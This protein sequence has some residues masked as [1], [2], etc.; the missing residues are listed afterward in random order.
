MRKCVFPSLL[1]ATQQAIQCALENCAGS[2]N[3]RFLIGIDATCGNGYDTLFLYKNFR[4][5]SIGKHF[6]IL[7]FDIQQTALDTTKALLQKN[8]CLDH[9][10]L[11]LKNHAFIS[12]EL[13]RYEREMN[14]SSTL[15]AVMYNL[16]FLPRS[17]K[18]I[19]TTKESTLASLNAVL[20]LLAE[21]GILTVHAYGG[22]PGGKEELDAVDDWCAALPSEWVCV[23]YSMHNKPKTPEALFLVQKRIAHDHD[24]KALAEDAWKQK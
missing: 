22:H 5:Q 24:R 6:S 13:T 21:E 1:K 17:D 11:L 18:Q 20:P 7:S 10:K 9:A 8:G 15:C 16:G 12:E 2:E 23:R 19:V 14:V 4:S 3:S